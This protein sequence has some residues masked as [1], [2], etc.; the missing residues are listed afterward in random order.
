MDAMT[1]KLLDTLPAGRPLAVIALLL[2]VVLVARLP[3]LLLVPHL[4]G[5][6]VVAIVSAA[7][8]LPGRGPARSQGLARAFFLEECQSS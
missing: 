4:S 7:C 1:E 8:N 3:E 6:L 5:L 2:L